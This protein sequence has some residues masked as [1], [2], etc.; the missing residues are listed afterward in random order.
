MGGGEKKVDRHFTGNFWLMEVLIFGSLAESVVFNK[1]LHFRKTA[2]CIENVS[3][4]FVQKTVIVCSH[5]MAVQIV[6]KKWECEL[7]FS[8][9]GHYMWFLAN[10][11]SVI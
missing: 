2:A 4:F 6:F 10:H 5:Q 1:K 11:N 7:L 9:I 3:L 8:S